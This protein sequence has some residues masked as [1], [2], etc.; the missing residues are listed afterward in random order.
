MDSLK[1][2]RIQNQSP[3]KR[4]LIIHQTNYWIRI[5]SL[6]RISFQLPDDRPWPRRN[7]VIKKFYLTLQHLN[8]TDKLLVHINSFSL[9]PNNY[10]LPETIRLDDI[11]LLILD[12]VHKPLD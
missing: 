5:L 4:I 7:S 12:Q 9:N 10:I 6:S 2:E 1:K 8:Q 11:Y 3:I